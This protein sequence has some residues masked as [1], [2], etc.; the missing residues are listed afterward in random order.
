MHMHCDAP[1][2]SCCCCCR[3]CCCC[4]TA[5]A[6][7]VLPQLLMSLFESSEASKK[8][9]GGSLGGAPGDLQDAWRRH[10]TP[11][12]SVRAPRGAVRRRCGCARALWGHGAQL[13]THCPAHL[14]DARPH[15]CM[16]G[17]CL[18]RTLTDCGAWLRR[19]PPQGPGVGAGRRARVAPAA[20]AVPAA[21]GTAAAGVRQGEVPHAY[22]CACACAC[23]CVS[24]SPAARQRAWRT[25]LLASPAAPSVACSRHQR[26]TTAATRAAMS[27]AAAVAALMMPRAPAPSAPATSSLPTLPACSPRTTATPRLLPPAA[28]RL[29]LAP[30]ALPLPLAAAA[31]AKR[32]LRGAEA[33][34]RPLTPAAATA[35]ARSSSC[36]AM[37]SAVTRRR[38]PRW[39]AGWSRTCRSRRGSGASSG[40]SSS[41]WVGGSRRSRARG[42]WGL[43]R[44]PRM[45]RG[46]RAGARA[47]GWAVWPWCCGTRPTC[48]C[49]R[50][51]SW[52]AC[53]G[54]RARVCVCVWRGGRQPTLQAAGTPSASALAHQ[55]RRSCCSA[56]PCCRR[57]PPP[58]G[59]TPSTRT[60][61]VPVAQ[62][63]ARGRPPARVPAAPHGA[64]GSCAL[65]P[66]HQQ[67]FD[68]AAAH[69]AAAHGAAWP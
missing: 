58:D 18:P 3:C 15:P 48:T 52:S 14:A 59:D 27:A 8:Q 64:G 10:K 5:C 51:R 60:P 53:I 23:A 20:P 29:A 22:A 36:R 66:A 38:T 45:R 54:A 35:A 65:Q 30:R 43:L 40:S 67:L 61:Q 44:M 37:A 28:A 12:D 50:P 11:Y 32:L 63:A 33:G 19:A 46:Q 2:Y 42:A 4:A 57:P 47:G 25:D 24:C 56:A 69:Q 49:S 39:A 68:A 41:R 7:I 55:C 17:C 6:V 31:S 34:L 21:A 16:P 13:A 1:H 26:L 62:P 9:R